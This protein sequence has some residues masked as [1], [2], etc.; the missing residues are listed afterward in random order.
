MLTVCGQSCLKVDIVCPS[1]NLIADCEDEILR[2]IKDNPERPV[3]QIYEEVF[4]PAS[5]EILM[6]R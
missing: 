4:T 6:N 1:S 2:K 5:S 3:M